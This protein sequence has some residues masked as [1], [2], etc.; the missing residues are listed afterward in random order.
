MPA[1]APPLNTQTQ[2]TEYLDPILQRKTAFP[3]AP[4][5][6]SKFLDD[7]LTSNYTLPTGK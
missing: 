6:H 2:I 3:K 4:T 1:P 5:N 7:F